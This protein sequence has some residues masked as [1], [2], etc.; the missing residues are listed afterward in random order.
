MQFLMFEVSV[1][2]PHRSVKFILSTVLS[3]HT[4]TTLHALI[5]QMSHFNST[6]EKV[7]RVH[8]PK[9]FFEV[10]SSRPH[11]RRQARLEAE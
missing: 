2:K 9:R 6:C 8:L 11:Q 7:P 5:L 3:V 10:M 1:S 4:I